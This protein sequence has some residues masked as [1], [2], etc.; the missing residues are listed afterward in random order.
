MANFPVSKFKVKLKLAINRLRFLQAKQESLN[1]AARRDIAMLLKGGKVASATI[2]IESIIRDDLHIEAMEITELFC[3]LLY[4]R[5]GLV[6]QSQEVNPGLSEAVSS[7]IYASTRIDVKELTRIRE[8]LAGRYG[9]DVVNN[10]MD[11]KDKQV[12]T[13][14]LQK[15]SVEP[16]PEKLV[17]MYLKEV[18]AAYHIRWVSHDDQ[19]DDDSPGNGGIKEP[20][21]LSP[22]SAEL[23]P[24]S[25]SGNDDTD[26]A[27][28]KTD[29]VKDTPKES[30]DGGDGAETLPETPH[31]KSP[32]AEP[33]IKAKPKDLPATA[34]PLEAA[35]TQ[36]TPSKEPAR[37]ALPAKD[38]NVPQTSNGAPTMDELQRRFEALKRL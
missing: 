33:A 19:D 4:A 17:R 16:P 1:T 9:K 29:D 38:V 11:N 31:F 23:I 7:V 25:P 5:A 14:L 15:L 12:N 26:A 13:K 21:P 3:E 35:P 34:E 32:E 8:M 10:A 6:D 18:A 24:E 36:A 20:A 22:S 30:N 37:K 28:S 27:E 2:R